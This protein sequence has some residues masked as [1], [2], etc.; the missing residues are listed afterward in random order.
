ML[1]LSSSYSNVAVNR[2]PINYIKTDDHAAVSN[3]LTTIA[4]CI[5][6]VPPPPPQS[7]RE[8]WQMQHTVSDG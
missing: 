5:K 1:L 7:V 6:N 3:M 2:E 8:A 4:G